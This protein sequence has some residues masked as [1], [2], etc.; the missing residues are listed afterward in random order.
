MT[1][2]KRIRNSITWLFM[3]VSVIDNVIVVF[4]F[5]VCYLYFVHK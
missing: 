2:F 4:F 1:N 5:Y 3:Y